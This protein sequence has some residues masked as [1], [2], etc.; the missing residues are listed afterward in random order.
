VKPKSRY[1][2][3]AS[4]AT[5]TLR[6]LPKPLLRRG[7]NWL[8]AWRLPW[9]VGRLELQRYFEQFGP[10]RQSQVDYNIGTGLSYGFG[11]VRMRNKEDIEKAVE[12][13]PHLFEG[14]MIGVQKAAFAS[15]RPRTDAVG[16]LRAK[17]EPEAEDAIE[18]PET[19]AKKPKF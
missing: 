1:Q 19:E 10:V 9:T 2:T 4:K 17:I 12:H 5:S 15:L 11:F 14:K 3:M 13:R 16:D 7:Q 6:R 18:Q 8:F